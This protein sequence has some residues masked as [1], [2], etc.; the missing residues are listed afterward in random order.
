VITV[1]FDVHFA[2]RSNRSKLGRGVCG[3]PFEA[4]DLHVEKVNLSDLGSNDHFEHL[5]RDRVRA[6]GC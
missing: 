3:L 4:G 2:G 5:L 6:G 1:S